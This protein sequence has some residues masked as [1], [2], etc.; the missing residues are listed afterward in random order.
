MKQ[1]SRLRVHIAFGVGL[2]AIILIGF[3]SHLISHERLGQ[4]AWGALSDIR[5]VEWLMFFV[6]WYSVAWGRPSPNP[7]RTATL[8]LSG[9]Q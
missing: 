4:A 6:V 3:V 1:G 2:V 5:P 8:E 7:N 9:K